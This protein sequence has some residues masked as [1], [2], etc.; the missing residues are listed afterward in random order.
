VIVGDARHK[1]AI[2]NLPVIERDAIVERGT[3]T[4]N[5]IIQYNDSFPAGSQEFHRYAANI[6]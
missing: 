6:A 2:A 4:S 3:V 5:Q 1:C